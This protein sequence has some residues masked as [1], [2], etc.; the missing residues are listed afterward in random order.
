MILG[1]GMGRDESYY[2]M[3]AAS[4]RQLDPAFYINSPDFPAEVHFQ[5][6]NGQSYCNAPFTFRTSIQYPLS[7]AAGHLKWYIGG[8]GGTDEYERM[9]ARDQNTWTMPIDG[10]LGTHRIR[11]RITDATNNTKDVI[12]EF[13]VLSIPVAIPAPD[14]SAAA[15]CQG[16]AP[17][18]TVA[19]TNASL[20]Y[21]VWSAIT[22]GA[23]PVGSA[24]GTGGTINIACTG[25]LNAN[26]IYYVESFN[27]VCP[28]SPR[29]PVSIAVTTRP[30]VPSLSAAAICN[31]SNPV[32]RLASSVGG[33]NYN[34]YTAASGGSAV[35]TA[36]GTGAALDITLSETPSSSKTYYVEAALGSCL[37][38]TRSSVAVSVNPKP[39]LQAANVAATNVS[40]NGAGNGTITVSGFVAGT[41]YSIDNG[42]SWQ[43]SASFTGLSSGTY[44]VKIKNTSG[45]ESDAVS[46]T[47]SENTAITASAT[48]THAACAGA[49]GTIT[50]TASGGTLPY[51]YQLNS[52]GY[53]SSNQFT[54]VAAGVHN[55]TVRDNAGCEKLLSGITINEPSTL[56]M[57]ITVGNRSCNVAN[58]GTNDGSISIAASGGT[59]AYLYSIGGSTFQ[60]SNLFSNVAVGAYYVVTKDANGCTV[61]NTLVQVSQPLI[62]EIESADLAITH[63]SCNGGAD[64]S[65]TVSGISGGTA[66]Y[67]YSFDGGSTYGSA[68]THGPLAAGS[69]S[70]YVRD[71]KGCTANRSYLVNQ[72]D[73][74]LNP[75]QVSYPLAC[76]QDAKV[77]ITVSQTGV[78]Y[79]VYDSRTGGS[80]KG[81]AAGNGS[82]LDIAVNVA[83]EPDSLFVETFAAPS[84][85]SISR[86]GVKTNILKTLPVYP[87][88]RLQLCPTP[89]RSIYLSGYLD[90]MHFVGVQWS[91]V[92]AHSPDFV[93]STATTTGELPA[94]GFQ[95]GTHVYRYN[96]QNACA[97][98]SGLV[99]IKVLTNSVIGYTP[100]T[101]VVCRSMYLSS[102]VQLTQMLG[103]ELNGVWSYDAA[104]NPFVDA[105]GSASQFPGSNVF[106]AKGAWEALKDN[107]TYKHQ[108]LDDANSAMFK[109]Y[110][111]TGTYATPPTQSCVGDMRKEL[112][113]IVTSKLGVGK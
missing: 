65:V 107:P 64:G 87:D 5:D 113:I 111:S 75:S 12:T 32:I 90:T 41:Q 23:T 70:V 2:Y 69:Y 96:I 35:G 86:I 67:E 85:T 21:R 68:T 13:T 19:N 60:A 1:Y 8:P 98:G 94:G 112:V 26:T 18:V 76:P 29:T 11:L 24:A 106:D 44:S 59:P 47:I 37:S 63:V 110:Y 103:Y 78:T 56:T 77:R 53:Q 17:T 38:N 51:Q 42:V 43:A 108:Y 102:Y 93:A 82:T 30:A 9:E 89:A 99:Y 50:I 25:N 66:P 72:P 40:C 79:S 105:S 6:A 58:G 54:T 80:L 39:N 27:G 109:F 55:V 15:I 97:P 100:D 22:G 92:Y 45:C 16:T 52:G 3:A 36:A 34:V 49:T 74:L 61:S 84:C 88:I 20:T 101:V 83:S 73:A 48:L 95:L 104:L 14:L 81:S 31:G 91:R 62:L 4:A 10:L 33:V 46:K 57:D 7:S 28:S 71:S